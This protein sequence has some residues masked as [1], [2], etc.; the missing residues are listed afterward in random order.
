M[1]INLSS[2]VGS[3]GQSVQYAKAWVNFNGTSST[4]ISPNA[5]YNISSITVNGTGNY[6]LNFTNSLTDTYYTVAFGT[7]GTGGT[8]NTS[9]TIYGTDSVGTPVTKTQNALRITSGSSGTGSLINLNN[10][11]VTIFGN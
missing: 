4:P 9:C 2:I 1:A 5:N 6:T 7:G 3:P 10:I 11:S 8:N